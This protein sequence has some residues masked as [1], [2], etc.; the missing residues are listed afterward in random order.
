[1]AKLAR[2]DHE[3]SINVF[4]AHDSSMDGPLESI[5]TGKQFVTLKGDLEELKL[6]KRRDRTAGYGSKA[7]M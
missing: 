5:G 7:K 3:E 2:L 4:M 1:M 6:L